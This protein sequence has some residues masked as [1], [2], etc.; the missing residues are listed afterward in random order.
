MVTIRV[1]FK[2]NK[3][4]MYWPQTFHKKKNIYLCVCVYIYIYIYM[5]SIYIYIYLILYI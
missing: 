2:K 3:K 4:K 1:L 5:V